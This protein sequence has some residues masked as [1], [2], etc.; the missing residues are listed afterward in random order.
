M[1]A[2]HGLEF[3]LVRDV[4]VALG[5]ELKL[6]FQFPDDLAAVYRQ[7][8]INLPEV[9]GSDSWELPMPARYLVDNNGLIR[10]AEI[11]PN[12]TRR[13]EPSGMLGLLE[14]LA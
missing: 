3:P 13:P 7:F 2:K 8:G 9:N 5:R 12:Y 6:V 1:A 11:N 4:D 10:D 14:M